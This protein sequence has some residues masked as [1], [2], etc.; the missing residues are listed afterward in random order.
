[1]TEIITKAEDMT[2]KEW[3]KIC[4]ML[5]EHHGIFYKIWS[6]GKPMFTKQ[7]PTACVTFDK[8][9]SFAFFL[10]NPEFWNSLNDYNKLFVICHECIH[11]LFN[12]GFRFKDSKNPTLSNF[13]MDIVVNHTLCRQFGFDRSQIKDSETLCWID[14]LLK[15][16]KHDGFPI[17]DSETVE[18]Y[19]NLLRKKQ[20]KQ[21]QQPQKSQGSSEKQN[22]DSQDSQNS[23]GQ[24]GD[25][26]ASQG[27]GNGVRTLDQHTF[28]S[29][30]TADGTASGDSPDLSKLVEKLAQSLSEEEA[31]SFA[32]TFNK[33]KD[34]TCKPMTP[35]GTGHGSQQ[36][37]VNPMKLKAKKKWESIV[38]KW[39]IRHMKE[40]D[41]DVEQWARKHRRF[42]MLGNSL[43]LPSDMEMETWNMEKS[44]LVVHFYLDTSGS[45][46]HL[47]DRFFS[48]AASLPKHKF[49][50]KL[51][52]FDTAVVETDLKSQ[53]VYGRGGTSFLIIEQHI[54]TLIQNA[55]QEGKKGSYPDAVWVLT[56]GYGDQVKPAKP[57]NWYW[58]LDV[59]DKHQ[60]D[61]VVKMYIPKES[62]KFNLKDFA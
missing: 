62:N 9:G 47:K 51:F 56:D 59:F 13:A 6:I 49:D 33:H 5:Q 10:F 24:Q 34:G 26:D 37:Q 31:D 29:D 55:R 48:V 40:A 45:C 16:A 53:K 32:Q 57:E 61:Q 22:Q 60:L 30:S 54:Q 28:D 42:N 46:W 58:F 1:M 8:Q 7:I 50:V 18:F 2:A 21:Q 44:K 35:A 27:F 11:I 12:H 36:H 25:P 41:T 4:A 52:C 14:T 39:T 20:N 3:Q 43:F 17:R 38:K 15:G 19:L 23:Q